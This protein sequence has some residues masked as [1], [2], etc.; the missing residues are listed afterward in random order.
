VTEGRK[1]RGWVGWKSYGGRVVLVS[2]IMKFTRRYSSSGLLP[3]PEAWP[4][5][6]PT[7]MNRNYYSGGKGEAGLYFL[8]EE[9]LELLLF[10]FSFAFTRCVEIF[11]FRIPA[12]TSPLALFGA[13][14][15]DA[16]LFG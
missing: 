6:G 14:E 4:M 15:E 12:V 2:Q 9:V 5:E 16:L 1:G 11:G 13:E 8:E 7:Y 3:C 10:F